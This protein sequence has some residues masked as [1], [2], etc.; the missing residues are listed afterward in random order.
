MP[1]RV[2]LVGLPIEP[3][4]ILSIGRKVGRQSQA[5]LV[6]RLRAAVPHVEQASRVRGRLGKALKADEP[7]GPRR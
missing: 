6:A 2:E 4:L 1:A 5:E 3:A 7:N